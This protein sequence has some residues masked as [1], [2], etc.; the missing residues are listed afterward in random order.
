MPFLPPRQRQFQV[1]VEHLGLLPGL[2]IL[3]PLERRVI[4]PVGGRVFEEDARVVLNGLA[5]VLPDGGQAGHV[6][7]EAVAV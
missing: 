6:G 2:G 5:S 1:G 4:A 3:G 7:G